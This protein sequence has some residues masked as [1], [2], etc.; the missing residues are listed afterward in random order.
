[1]F[2]LLMVLGVLSSLGP[3]LCLA[4]G[5]G[6]FCRILADRYADLELRGQRTAETPDG[7]RFM[8]SEWRHYAH[9]TFWG[10]QGVHVSSVVTNQD[11]MATIL[12]FSRQCQSVDVQLVLVP[13]PGK[14]VIYPEQIHTGLVSETRLDVVHE[15]FYRLLHDE[16]IVVQ[17]LTPEF[18]SVKRIG[19]DTHWR[20]DDHWSPAAVHKTAQ[21]IASWIKTQ[22]WYAAVPRKTFRRTPQSILSS[23][24][25]RGL[26]DAGSVAVETAMLDRVSCDGVP[27]ESDPKS[28][29]VLI[30]DSHVLVYSQSLTNGIKATGAGLFDQLAAEIGFALDLQAT[31]DGGASGA[32][33]KLA[34]N[35]ANLA[36]VK[37]VIWCFATR[38]LTESTEGWRR[39][40]V[41]R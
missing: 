27:V 11:P 7:F 34:L 6:N 21:L 5:A 12:D 2:R 3:A 16:G 15:A 8:A 18:L 35:R 10:T 24:D 29:V 4:D 13:V 19:V 39:I 33:L 30:G 17:D 22:S 28:P 37:C 40:P 32:R 9:G 38:E 36:G 25:L 31:S 26:S 41:V 14:T 1:M 23:G 20:Q